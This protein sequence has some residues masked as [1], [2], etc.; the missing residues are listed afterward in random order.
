MPA[1]ICIV[2]GIS[3][4]RGRPAVA[5]SEVPTGGVNVVGSVFPPAVVPAT[6]GAKVAPSGK[7]TSRSLRL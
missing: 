4:C 7:M 2:A 6:N 1:G 5:G 3:N